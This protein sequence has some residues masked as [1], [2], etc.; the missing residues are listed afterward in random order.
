MTIL[1][2]KYALLANSALTF[3]VFVCGLLMKPFEISKT[4][5]NSPEDGEERFLDENSLSEEIP[6][7]ANFFTRFCRTLSIL[8]NPA[9]ALFCVNNL[10]F[11]AAM[12]ILWVHLNGYI[13]S[14]DL[15]DSTQAGLV[16]SVIGI[17]N[18]AGRVFLGVFCDQKR[19]NPVVVYTI[20][21]F[22]LALNELYASFAQT[23]GG[24][25]KK[26]VKKWSKWSKNG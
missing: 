23:F 22:F 2:W 20:G 15:G 6:K 21:N 16:Y 4:D 19:V 3:I 12:T 17:S 25:F 9:Y 10:L 11:F 24:N 8:R 1:G 26:L 18:V 7:S 13:V 14:S 5:E